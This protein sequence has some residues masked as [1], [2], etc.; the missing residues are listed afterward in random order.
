MSAMVQRAPSFPNSVWERN[1][2]NSVSR[3][4]PGRRRNAKRSFATCVPK[5]SLGTRETEFGNEGKRGK[6]GSEGRRNAYRCRVT[7]TCLHISSSGHVEHFGA[8][9]VQTC[10]PNGTS[11]ALISTQYD[12]GSFSIKAAI[13]FSGVAAST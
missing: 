2:R 10:L 8:D 6:R 4:R 7:P 1:S 12:R 9:P 13:V 11:S 5:R 3:D